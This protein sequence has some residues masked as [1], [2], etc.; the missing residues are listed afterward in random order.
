MGHYIHKFLCL[1]WSLLSLSLLP[2]SLSFSSA[3][4]K[5]SSDSYSSLDAVSYYERVSEKLI[6]NSM[7]MFKK[8]NSLF[9][10]IPDSVEEF[11]EVEVFRGSIFSPCDSLKISCT[12]DL[13]AHA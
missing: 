3:F 13:R 1:S 5:Y 8:Y 7:W 4:I 12:C 10:L 6:R 9:S 11:P 2:T